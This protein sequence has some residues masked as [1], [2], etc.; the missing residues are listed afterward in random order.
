MK[1]KLVYFTHMTINAFIYFRVVLKH[2]LLRSS[3]P[4]HYDVFLWEVIARSV[5]LA[6]WDRTDFPAL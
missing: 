4:T 6:G 3:F 1:T 2:Q 5:E